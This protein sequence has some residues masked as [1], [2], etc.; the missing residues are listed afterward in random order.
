MARS[1]TV[2]HDEI[3]STSPLLNSFLL[4]A[5]GWLLISGLSAAASMSAPER[6]TTGPP[7]DSELESGR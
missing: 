3:P 2:K 7:A 6:P 5:L 1:L 4:L